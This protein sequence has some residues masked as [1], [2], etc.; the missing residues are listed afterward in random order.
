MNQSSR[1][2]PL[3]NFDFAECTAHLFVDDAAS[4]VHAVLAA[5]LPGNHQYFPAETIE[6]GGFPL[7]EM[8]RERFPDV[9]LK[10]P[11]HEGDALIDRSALERDVGWSPRNRLRLEVER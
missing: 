6:L 10:C 2:A 8:P 9:V 1:R 4:L 5:G 3:S 7:S 11:L